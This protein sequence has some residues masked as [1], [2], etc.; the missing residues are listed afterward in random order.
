MNLS[1]ENKTAIVCGSTQGIGL[2][3]AIELASLGANCVLIARNEASL[4]E[5]VEKLDT[6]K[7]QQHKYLVADFSKP[8]QLKPA[9]ENFMEQN[10]VHIL[11]NNTGGP[12]AGA[13]IDAIEDDFLNAFNQHLIC[14][15]ILTKAVVPS[16]KEARYG[17]IINIISSSVKIPLNN[18]GVS[19]TIRGAVASWA[20][21]M[22]NEL[23]QFNI[24]VNNILPGTIQTQR[25]ESLIKTTASKHSVEVKHAEHKMQQEV[26]MKRFGDASELAAVAAFLASPAASYVNGV[27][28]PVDGGRTGSI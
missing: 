7:G 11:I 12:P 9:I 5:A 18:L 26:P 25:L 27:S 4:Q 24:T 20:K 28:I 1:L 10:I 6:S 15:H 22:A 14:N 2:A 23:G 13:I 19:N 17:R 8:L 3:C 21:T 16:M